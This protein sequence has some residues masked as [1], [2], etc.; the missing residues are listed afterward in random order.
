[1]SE[2]KKDN[3]LDISVVIPIYNEEECI[4]SSLQEVA[5][6]MRNVGQSW[7]IL[8]ID[9]GSTDD[10]PSILKA[11]VKSIPEIRILKLVPNAG[12]SAAFGVGFRNAFGNTIITMDADGQNDPA[13]IPKLLA[14]LKT[15]DC[16]FGYR[17]TRKDNFGKRISS[18]IG[19]GSRN[20]VLKE[21]IID[22]GCSLKAFPTELARNLKM[23]H[24]M[25][26]FL[27]SLLTMNGASISQIPVN[28]RPRE[29]GTSKYTNFGRLKQTVWDLLAVRWMKKRNPQFVVE[30]G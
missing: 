3:A 18:K 5:G 28:H 26:R 25:H 21:S 13:D 27:G 11:L 10:T 6:V 20:W 9:D 16:C 22:T 8:A 14:E 12:Q 7:E 2:Q 4:E 15:H 29:L 30:K 1:M 17:A 19:N 24:G 23:W